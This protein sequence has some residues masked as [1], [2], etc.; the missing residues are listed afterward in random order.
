M[1]EIDCSLCKKL[2]NN[3]RKTKKVMLDLAKIINITH[4]SLFFFDHIISNSGT[5]NPHSK[6][7]SKI[8]IELCLMRME[9]LTSSPRS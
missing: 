9:E 6:Y 1:K 3:F 7:Q 8:N 4:F 2:S 5:L